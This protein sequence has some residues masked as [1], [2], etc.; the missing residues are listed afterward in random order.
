MC[1][2]Q[3]WTLGSDANKHSH[4][5]LRV[6]TWVTLRG[7]P[8][9]FMKVSNQ[10]ASGLRVLLGG[11]NRSAVSSDQRFCVA[12]EAGVEWRTLLSVSNEAT[13][14]VSLIS[15]DYCNLPIRCQFCLSTNHLVK[16]CTGTR[17]MKEIGGR[18]NRTK[19]PP[20]PGAS[21]TSVPQAPSSTNLRNHEVEQ[22]PP[23]PHFDTMV[24]L[25][26]PAISPS[27]NRSRVA[28]SMTPVRLSPRTSGLGDNEADANMEWLPT[29]PQGPEKALP[30]WVQ[31]DVPTGYVFGSHSPSL[32]PVLPSPTV[33]ML[34]SGTARENPLILSPNNVAH[35]DDFRGQGRDCHTTRYPNMGNF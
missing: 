11:D 9:E 35:S 17:S 6:P 28:T 20:Q 16:E 12:M 10:I 24:E 2:L 27:F 15:V 26:H 14:K 25:T 8:G 31:S 21:A 18:E 1:I 29:E 7:I 4:I 5:G 13:G 22:P 34:Q 23:R 32:V 33:N 3:T 19:T 30:T